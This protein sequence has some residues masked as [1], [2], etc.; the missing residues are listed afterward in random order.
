MPIGSS[1][2]RRSRTS[3]M[4]VA[5]DLEVSFVIGRPVRP[6][7]PVNRGVEPADD[8]RR[9]TRRENGSR[10]RPPVMAPSRNPRKGVRQP[11]SRIA[12]AVPRDHRSVSI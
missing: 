9:S 10:A 12:P 1:S 6:R 8:D 4:R 3:V 7:M 11:T 2:V 5:P